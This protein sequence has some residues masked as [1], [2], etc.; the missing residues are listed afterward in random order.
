VGKG[1]RRE[2]GARTGC[3]CAAW[4]EG[5]GV[6]RETRRTAAQLAGWLAIATCIV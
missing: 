5:L 1:E 3:R 4:S 6:A 2:E